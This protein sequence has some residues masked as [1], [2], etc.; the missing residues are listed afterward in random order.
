MC[1][2]VGVFREGGEADPG[3]I[4]RML[5]TIEHRGPD[6]SGL[7]HGGPVALG[8]RRLAIIDPSIGSHQPFVT[9]DGRGVLVY[10][11]EIYNYRE[12]RRDLERAGGR[13]RS[14]GDTEVVLQALHHWGVEESVLRFNGM[15][16]FAYFDRRSEALWLAR[17]RVGIKP[18][19][20][21]GVGR[22]LL[23]GSEAKALLANPHFAPRI[24]R[25]AVASW[26]LRRRRGTEHSLFEGIEGVRPGSWWK[27]TAAGIT[28]HRYFDAIETIDIDRLVAA[29]GDRPDVYV[30][31]FGGMLRASVR[32]HLVSDAPLATM[33]SGGVDS[34]LLT[35]YANEAAPGITAYVADAPPGGGEGDQAER[36]GRHLGVAI[37]RVAVGPEAFLRLWPETVWHSDGPTVH[38]S[39]AALLMVARRCRKDGIKVLLTGEGA[40][41]LFGGYSDYRATHRKW[42]YAF[43]WERFLMPAAFRRLSL[44]TLEAAPFSTMA[45]RLDHG[46]RDRLTLV[47][48]PET[49]LM[50]GRLMTAL[51]RVEPVA[52]RAFLAHCLF[53]LNDKLGWILHHHDRMGMAASIEMRVPFLENGMFDL[54]FHMPHRA[55]LQRRT[56]KWAVK[57]VA[58]QSL[59]DGVVHAKKKGF[60]IPADFTRGAERLLAGGMVADF[61]EWPAYAEDQISARLVRDDNLRFHL[62]GLEI[63]MRM[64]IAGETAESIG[65]HLVAAQS[66]ASF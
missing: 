57:K 47:A 43:G 33:C 32:S 28:K 59:P 3:V 53:D 54:A 4:P 9:E 61:L 31:R 10:N 40:D 44:R 52:D 58:A 35:A 39:D 26:L 38:P 60:P 64:F 41:E 49:D 21:A 56:G 11:G 55:R 51:A 17:D 45:G 46:Q 27:V 30:D 65:D 15:F 20:T 12:L 22:D 2:F 48:D 29:A 24:D 16:A 14:S 66:R 25:F 13:F 5:A 6:D 18:L 62:V 37:H 1:G 42:R 7:W 19:L 8:H 23:F 34:G 36:V 50:A 63:W